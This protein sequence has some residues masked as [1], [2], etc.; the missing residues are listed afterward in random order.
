LD[1]KITNG[2]SVTRIWDN[3]HTEF[4][5]AFQYETHAISFAK[6][7]AAEDRDTRVWYIVSNH[8]SGGVPIVRPQPKTAAQAA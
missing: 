1:L 8:H 7:C 5:A 6:D 2:S 3:D 4:L